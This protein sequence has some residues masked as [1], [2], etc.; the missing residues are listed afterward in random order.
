MEKETR[1]NSGAPMTEIYDKI[2]GHAVTQAQSDAE[3]VLDRAITAYNAVWEA[4]GDITS[5]TVNDVRRKAMQAALTQSD[6][7]PPKGALNAWRRYYHEA[8]VDFDPVAEEIFEAGWKAAIAQSDAEPSAARYDRAWDAV[9]ASDELA[10]VRRKL[11]IHDLRLLI[12]A[13]LTGSTAPPRPDAGLIEAAKRCTAEIVRGCIWPADSCTIEDDK[14]TAI[15]VD[16][17]RALA[18]TRTDKE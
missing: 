18:A 14:I 3:P 8:P 1:W 11:S 10:G 13:V 17:M 6:A 5:A 2:K 16:A 9:A 7:A 12:R 15:L 4:A